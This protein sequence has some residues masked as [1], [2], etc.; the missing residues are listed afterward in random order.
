MTEL[1]LVPAACLA[2]MGLLILLVGDSWQWAAAAIALVTTVIL[3]FDRMQALVS[4][5]IA[6]T[7]VAL[8][9]LRRVVAENIDLPG[10]FHAEVQATNSAAATVTIEGYPA[11]VTVFTDTELPIGTPVIVSGDAAPV[12][13]PSVAAHTVTGELTAVGDAGWPARVRERLRQ[14]VEKHV[15]GEHRGLIPGMVVGDTSLQGEAEDAYLATGL[16]HL[17]AVSGANVTILCTA[18]IIV[19]RLC[20]LGPRAQTVGA[21]LGLGLF[22]AIVGTEPSVLRAAITGVVGLMAVVFSSRTQPIHALSISVL[23]LLL[24]SPALA[25]SYGF[26]L[27]VAAT[28]GIIVI[29]PLI[30]APLIRV[31]IAPLIARAIAVAVAADVLTMPIIALMTGKVSLVSV[32]ANVLVAP[33]TAPITVLGMIATCLALVHSY[34]AVPIF[35]ILSPLTWWIHIVA[36]TL[37]SLPLVTINAHPI[38]VLIAYAWIITGIIAHRPRLTLTCLGI[39]VITLA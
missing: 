21:L 9:Q 3:R 25:I 34:L 32:L 4:A 18:I 15:G 12:S 10:S 26:A 22:V 35:W 2:W 30:A 27:S 38:Y 8:A 23:V 11:L 14:A 13:G 1:R 29:N 31:G 24:F 20:G 17:S 36:T 33:V 28:V 5:S 6:T 39:G 7:I 37:Y 16:S 19:C